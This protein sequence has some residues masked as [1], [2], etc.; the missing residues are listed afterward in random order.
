MK[1]KLYRIELRQDYS[2]LTQQ[3]VLISARSN[4]GEYY[5]ISE[6]KAVAETLR[7]SQPEYVVQQIGDSI[8]HIDKTEN[9]KTVHILSIT[10]V[11]VLELDMPEIT[12]EEAKDI[13][14]EIREHSPTLPQNN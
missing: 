10:E 2:Y 9:G 1:K 6:L 11:E 13:L 12:A 4:G 14:E 8:L 5:G 3:L 7:L